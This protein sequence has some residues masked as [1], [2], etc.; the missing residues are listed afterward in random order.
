MAAAHID[1]LDP[2]AK[3]MQASTDVADI[4][5]GVRLEGAPVEIAANTTANFPLLV[6]LGPKKENTLQGSIHAAAGTP[7]Y[8]HALFK[9]DTL[10]QFSTGCYSFCTFGI[11]FD[12]LAYLLL[13]ILDFFKS[14]VA[15]GNYGVAIMILVLLIRAA[16]HPLTRM[17]QIKMAE[18]GK[19]MKDIQ[20]LIEANKKKY[21][22]DKQKQ[23]EEMM[24]IYR[25][26]HVNPAGGVMGCLPMLIQMPIWIAMWAA[27]RADINLRHAVF[28]PGWINDLSAPDMTVVFHPIVIPLVG[29]HVSALNILPL[30]LGTVFFIQMQVQTASQP[31]P[32][33]PQQASMQKMT[34][35]FSLLFPLFL[36][37]FPSGL[38]LYYF[39]S[40]LGGLVDTYFVRKTLKK[41]GILP[42]TAQVLP[43]HE[44]KE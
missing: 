17:S 7:E 33:D 14:T 40:T 44:E 10:I 28:V 38:N 9:Y 32:A 12:G 18:M 11:G 34:K 20:P 1:I 19:K 15:F 37:N 3:D 26:H 27:L 31:V 16:L 25:E 36:Y 43:T 30:L 6:F 24:R 41:R 22:K 42:A 21:A 29:V 35:Y 4:V 23:N 8:T 39:A 5:S 13:H 2:S